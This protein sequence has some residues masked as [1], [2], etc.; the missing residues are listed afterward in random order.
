[1][2][3]EE[4]QMLTYD[5]KYV[6]FKRGELIESMRTFRKE[7]PELAMIAVVP[8]ALEDAVVI[9]RQDVF[10]PPA[11]DAYANAIVTVIEALKAIAVDGED[12]T[13]EEANDQVR[14]LQAIADYFHTQALMSW[15]T[16]RKVPD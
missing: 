2:S 10:A 7:H 16:E 13:L 14:R 8:D 1:M 11:L 15:D 9:R 5:E 4:R 3:E 6:V 12:A